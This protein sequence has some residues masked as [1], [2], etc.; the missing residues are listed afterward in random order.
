[1]QYMTGYI[2]Y[3]GRVTDDKDKRLITKILVKY[4]CPDALRDGYSYSDSGA[5]RSIEAGS[6]ADYISYI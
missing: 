5:Y 1:M 4:I 3:G 2:N 6:H